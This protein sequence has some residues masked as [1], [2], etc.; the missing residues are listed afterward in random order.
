MH[1]PLNIYEVP[2][3]MSQSRVYRVNKNCIL[4]TEQCPAHLACTLLLIAYC[5]LHCITTALEHRGS[6]REVLVE[7]HKTVLDPRAHIPRKLS[8]SGYAATPTL[9]QPQACPDVP[10]NNLS[11]IQIYPQT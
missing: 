8:T 3:M 7:E 2:T 5:T 6:I 10:G 1:C 11:T 9:R 4:H